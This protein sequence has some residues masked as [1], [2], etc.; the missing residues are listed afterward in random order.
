MDWF[1]NVK[2]IYLDQNIWIELSRAR[3]GRNGAKKD[4]V[5]VYELAKFASAHGMA[6]FVLSQTHMYETQK[7]QEWSKRLDVVET[8]IEISRFHAIKHVTSVVPVEA[9]YAIGLLG[10]HSP[11]PPNVFGFGIRDMLAKDIESFVKLAERF[12]LLQGWDALLLAGAPPGTASIEIRTALQAVDLAFASDQSGV[13]DKIRAL[14]LKGAA[15]EN[16]LMHYTLTEVRHELFRAASE[17][18]VPG[19][20]L[21][22]FMVAEPAS[23]LQML[24][25]RHVVHSMYMQHAQRQKN[26]KPNDL[27][28]IAALGVAIPYCDVVATERHWVTLL[29]QRKIDEGYGTILLASPTE[30]TAYLA[31]L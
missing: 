6:S 24:P 1:L 27:H 3:L 7:R 9:N 28:D 22:D 29:R 15:L 31:R 17:H 16:V 18:G 4:F 14:D 23:M 21:V 13:A 12:D 20:A 19:E 25:S 10:G 8:M 11:T 2:R 30:L 5:E 26:W